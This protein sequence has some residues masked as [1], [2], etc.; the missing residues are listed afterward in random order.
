MRRMG[1]LRIPEE[2]HPPEVLR[3]AAALHQQASNRPAADSVR[4][5]LDDSMFLAAHRQMLPP[6]R[7]PGIDPLNVPLL[8]GSAK[9]AEASCL[10][11]V[12]PTLDT[13]E[14]AA[15]LSDEPAL[16]LTTAS[17]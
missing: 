17:G 7:R 12:W 8:T 9:L 13:A 6:A 4:T 1:L 14:K 2:M 3:R 5:L 16:F 10:D 11:A 15:I